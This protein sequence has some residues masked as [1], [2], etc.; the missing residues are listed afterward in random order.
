VTIRAAAVSGRSPKVRQ[1]STSASAWSSFMCS[2]IPLACGRSGS[3]SAP[4]Y[5]SALTQLIRPKPPT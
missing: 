3:G 1:Y 2:M 4:V 5:S